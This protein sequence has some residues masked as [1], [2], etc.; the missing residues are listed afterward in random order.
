MLPGLN[1]HLISDGEFKN[2]GGPAVFATSP[3]LQPSVPV[4]INSASNAWL[5]VVA[6]AGCSLHRDGVD[7]SI[8]SELKSLGKTGHLI[9]AETAR[10]IEATA[11][12]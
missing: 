9:T 11:K 4:T 6:D 2:T 1:G 5:K 7:Q 10:N 12:K 8:I 3:F